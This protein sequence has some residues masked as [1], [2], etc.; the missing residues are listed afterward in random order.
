MRRQNMA[1]QA[2]IDLR[3]P[4]EILCKTLSLCLTNYAVSNEDVWRSG[5]ID[6]RF[7]YLGT[8]WR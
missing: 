4:G 7:L 6:L 5:C 3:A 2:V 8:N 1:E